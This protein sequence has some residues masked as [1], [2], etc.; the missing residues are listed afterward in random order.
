VL[1]AST[2]PGVEPAGMPPGPKGR[3]WEF[4]A[5]PSALADLA[6]DLPPPSTDPPTDIAQENDIHPPPPPPPP[7]PDEDAPPP[8]LD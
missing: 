2:R 6:D 4:N 3:H 5:P 8:P 1:Y 7:P